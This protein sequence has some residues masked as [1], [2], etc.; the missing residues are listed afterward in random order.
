MVL[1]DIKGLSEL[2]NNFAI[3][4]LQFSSKEDS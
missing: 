4:I 3:M 1:I 2:W